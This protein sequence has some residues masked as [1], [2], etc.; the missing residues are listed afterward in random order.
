MDR[1]FWAWA[2]EAY[3]RPGVAEACLDL[4][5]RFDQSVPYLLW[6]AWAAE[7]GR[8]IGPEGLAAGA[9]LADRW[10]ADVLVPLR[11]ARRGLKSFQPNMDDTVRQALR[12]EVKAL[13]LK[14]ERILME[15][16]ETLTLDVGFPATS[17]TQALAAAAEAWPRPVSAST[18]EPLAH[19]LS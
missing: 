7:A 6:A 4:Q 11:S 13:E 10:S 1:G 19:T 2:L 17:L 14:A 15:T 8:A 18:L 3:G 9:R 5:D 12:E 16:L